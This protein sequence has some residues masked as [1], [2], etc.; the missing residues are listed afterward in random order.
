MNDGVV[1]VAGDADEESLLCRPDRRALLQPEAGMERQDRQRARS[2][3]RGQA[4]ESRPVQDR[5]QV[6]AAQR[7]RGQ[8]LR[9]IRLRHRHQAAGHAAWPDDP[10][11]GGRRRP[12]K[13]R[14]KLD[15]GHPR[16]ARRADQGLPRRRR[17]QGMGCDPGGAE[18]ESA[19]VERQPPFPEQ[20]AIYDFIRKAPAARA[21]CRPTTAMSTRPS[22]PPRR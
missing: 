12:G 18:T 5:R 13:G 20:T 14:R 17:R 16:R 10:S 6:V 2:P 19:V 8:A 1:S 9:P 3:W 22:R 15:Q 21:K 4:E 7:Y 11:A